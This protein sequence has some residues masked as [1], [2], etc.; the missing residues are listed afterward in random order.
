M[1]GLLITGTDTGVG[2]TFMTCWLARKLRDEGYRVG[3]CKPV[4]S[5]AVFDA[6]RNAWTWPDVDA[7]SDALDFR[8]PQEQICPQMFRAPLA[9]SAAARL[10]S[11]RV[12][13]RRIREGVDAWSSLVEML[14][15]EGVGGWQCPLTERETVAD[16]ASVLGFPVLVVSPHRLGT[17][18]HTLLTVESIQRSGLALAGIVM[19]QMSASPDETAATNID[20]IRRFTSVPI[21]G[22]LPYQAPLELRRDQP[23]AS[24]VWG[25][26]IRETNQASRSGPGSN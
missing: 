15:I 10:E 24:I 21:L 25:N 19:N 6:R 7:L 22:T 23:L 2:K 1:L 16:L 20:E 18:N 5:G 11:S 9:P 12:D 13:M 8:F 3:A 4:C 17:I 14:L 26:F